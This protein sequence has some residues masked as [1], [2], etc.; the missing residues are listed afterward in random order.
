VTVGVGETLAAPAFWKFLREQ[1]KL[2]HQYIRTN[3]N[4]LLLTARLAVDIVNSALSEISIS[5]DAASADTYQ[6]IRG[7]KFSGALEGVR[8]LVEARNAHPSSDLLIFANITLMRENLE[9]LEDFVV[10]GHQL[11]VDAVVC[12]QLFS[13]GDVP[14]WIVSRGN[15]DF[16]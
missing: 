15:W 14:E 6:K 8:M 9:E 12:S 10:L 16:H 1:P 5:L 2:P 3:S 4:A 13:F 7:G 11:G